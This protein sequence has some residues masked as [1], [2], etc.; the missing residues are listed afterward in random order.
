VKFEMQKSLMLSENVYGFIS[1]IKKSFEEKNSNRF[2]PDKLLQVK[3]L[4]E[5]YKFKQLAD[6]LHRINQFE[7]DGKYSYILIN[8]IESGLRV[9]T[10]Y[11]QNNYEDLFFLTA[12]IYT[13]NQLCLSFTRS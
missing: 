1:Y 10:E 11:V 3:L 2:H 12:R 8:E 6:E 5:E 13:L 4:V 7:W 9:I